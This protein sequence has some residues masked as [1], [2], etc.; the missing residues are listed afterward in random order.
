MF[1]LVFVNKI[2]A[3]QKFINKM[4]ICLY[5]NLS[6]LHFNVDIEKSIHLEN[7]DVNVVLIKHSCVT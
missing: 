2:V 7:P 5:V 1:Y 3:T 6:N 4:K